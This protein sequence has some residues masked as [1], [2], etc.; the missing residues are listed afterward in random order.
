MQII[1]Y[2]QDNGIPAIIAP[3]PEALLFMTIEQI[4]NKDVPAGKPYKIINSE[5]LP[6]DTPQEAWIVNDSDL[7]DGFGGT[8]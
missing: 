4:A 3:S 1:I 8:L 5:E 7:T 6:I 2:N